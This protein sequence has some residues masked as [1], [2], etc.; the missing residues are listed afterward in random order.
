MAIA[1]DI[2][3]KV[4][5]WP[6]GRNEPS[7]AVVHA[8]GTPLLLAGEGRRRGERK[9]SG[10][11]LRMFLHRIAMLA[12]VL[13]TLLGIGVLP[14]SA[15]AT[16]DAVRQRGELL[17]G[18]SEGIAGFSA[19]DAQ[20]IWTGLDVDFCRALAAAIFNDPGKV[21]FVP[22]SPEG[23]FASLVSGAVDVL[24]RNTTWTLTREATM[25]IQFAAVT[26]YDGQGFM[27]RKSQERSSAR[28]LDGANICVQSGTTTELNLDDYFSVNGI[29]YTKISVPS[30]TQAVQAYAEGRC[31]VLTSDIGQ[32]YA[33]RQLL[34][35]PDENVV[36]P[37]I[38]SKEPL[39]PAVRASDASWLNIVKWTHN[40]MVYAEELGVS[41]ANIDEEMNANGA[42]I[43]RLLGIHPGLG[44]ALG[45]PDDWAARI[46]RH[47]GNYGESFARNLGSES[48]LHIP[49]GFNDLWTRGGLQY[50]P[51]FR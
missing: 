44:H 31:D 34:P 13:C 48:N 17:C 18:V 39:G 15:Q 29:A 21:S 24:S 26:Y 51:P 47:V 22:L 36:L 1:D 8:V 20:G 30:S 38:I 40:A 7:A 41:R 2:H 28:E 23:R 49:R 11:C 5:R 50:A 46:I 19:Q 10:I 35:A 27:V 14:V 9:S 33:A 42:E 12:A 6:S 4:V 25:G 45:L 32:L 3:T 16:L 43:K 37:D